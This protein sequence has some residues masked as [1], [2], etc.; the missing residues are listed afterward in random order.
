MPFSLQNCAIFPIIM[1]FGIVLPVSQRL[2][3]EKDACSA[4]AKE[5]WLRKPL[6]RMFLI[7][8]EK[9]I[10]F[11]LPVMA[12]HCYFSGIIIAFSWQND[13]LQLQKPVN[14]PIRHLIFRY[15]SSPSFFPKVFTESRY[16]IFLPDC[17]S[18]KF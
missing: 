13:N 17:F 14:H 4:F 2:I 12:K 15:I 9:L 6:C 7:S 8:S 1:Q 5:S 16:R 18:N 10:T 3:V 11:L